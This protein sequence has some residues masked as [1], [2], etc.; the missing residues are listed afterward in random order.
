M[1]RKIGEK[2]SNMSG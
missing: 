2:H 1:N